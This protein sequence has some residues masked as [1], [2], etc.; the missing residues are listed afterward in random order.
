M[1]PWQVAQ[2]GLGTPAGCGYS[3]WRVW[4]AGHPRLLCAC[5]L[6]LADTSAWQLRHSS[7]SLLADSCLL[8]GG[9]CDSSLGTNAT[10]NSRA[11][12]SCTPFTASL[13]SNLP[14][15]GCDRS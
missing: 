3:S 12:T 10:S 9:D 13:P 6:V 15:K 8:P 2:A 5:P 14:G 1:P 7:P 4:Q 11:A